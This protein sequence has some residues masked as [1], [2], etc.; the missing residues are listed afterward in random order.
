MDKK[1]NSLLV[2]ALRRFLLTS[3]PSS[4]E[5]ICSALAKLGYEINQTKASRL[6][7]QIGA[8]KVKDERGQIVYS[9]PREPA[10]PSMNSL[11]RDLVL[12]I[13][14]NEAMVVILTSP[15]AASMVARVID[16]S[17]IETGVLGTIAGD[18]T[19]FIAPQSI[20]QTS[21]LQSEIKSLL[22]GL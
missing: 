12:E 6:L 14:S 21:Q 13:R 22:L 8:V 9:L 10:P 17:Q 18:D 4:Q 15:G 1:K 5:A 7:H 2:D 16:Y 11:I 19:I 3:K 20:K